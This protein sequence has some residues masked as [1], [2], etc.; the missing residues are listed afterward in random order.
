MRYYR[1]CHDLD[2]ILYREIGDAHFKQKDDW[3]KY[4][5]VALEHENVHF[6]AAEEM[7]KLQRFNAPLIVLITYPEESAKDQML[8]KYSEIIHQADVLE[9]ASKNRR[10]LAMFGYKGGQWEAFVYKD[11]K[12]VPVPPQ[13]LAANA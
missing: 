7:I 6:T 11:G 10:Q 1:E 2:A 8:D 13:S 4:I 12:F 3:A 5:S 9:N